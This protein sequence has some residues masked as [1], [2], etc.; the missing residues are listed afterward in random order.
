MSFRGIQRSAQLLSLLAVALLAVGAYAG[1][2][3]PCHETKHAKVISIE[4]DDDDLILTRNCGENTKVVMINF[5]AIEDLVAD[6][7]DDV[8]DALEDMEDM[9][10]KIHLGE[11]NMLSF[12]DDGSEWAVD[13][14]QLAT[15]IQAVLQVGLA[16]FE[17]EDWTSHH[18]VSYQEDEMEDLQKELDSLRR[19][20]KR[21]E[22]LLEKNTDWDED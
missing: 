14:D 21:L 10:V 2:K 9:Q 16:E 19:E 17:H 11:D 12:S 13:L 22:K 4:L 15:S 18:S 1:D 8:S 7:L 20:M 5:D 6:A 3:E